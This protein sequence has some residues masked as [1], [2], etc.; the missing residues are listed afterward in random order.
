LEHPICR[1]S[2]F[3]G[4]VLELGLKDV[5]DRKDFASPLSQKYTSPGSAVWLSTYL[6]HRL[7]SN[8]TLAMYCL[9][10]V[11]Y[12]KYAF[13]LLDFVDTKGVNVQL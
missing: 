6:Q 13:H 1:V 5:A 12:A 4:I 9:K 8:S 11:K 2:Y 7:K 10:L 3:Y